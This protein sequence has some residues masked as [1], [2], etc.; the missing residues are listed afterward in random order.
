MLKTVHFL[1]LYFGVFST[2]CTESNVFSCF[3]FMN[4]VEDSADRKSG[5]A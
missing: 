4:M 3:P 2:A 5:R 1:E